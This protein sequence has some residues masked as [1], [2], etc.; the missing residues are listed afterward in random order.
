M[1][2]RGGPAVFPGARVGPASSAPSAARVS[3]RLHP[4]SSRLLFR[5]PSLILPPLLSGAL[6]DSGSKALFAAYRR[7]PLTARASDP[8][9]VPS[10]GFLNLPTVFS[11]F[12]LAGVSGP[13]ATSRV[14]SARP[15]RP[16]LSRWTRSSAASGVPW[17]ASMRRPAEYLLNVQEDPGGAIRSRA[18]PEPSPPRSSCVDSPAPPQRL[19]PEP[20]GPG[21]SAVCARGVSH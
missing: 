11:A 1:V 21:P 10:L 8:R 16:S 5:V 17:R 3:A 2:S 4:S 20:A 7:R 15:G 14:L 19:R 18:R 12:D 9:Y 6:P 13:A